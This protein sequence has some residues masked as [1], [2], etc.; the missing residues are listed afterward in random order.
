MTSILDLVKEVNTDWKQVLLESIHPHASIIDAML[1]KE[2]LDIF[3]ASD[4]IFAAFDKFD[5]QDLKVVIVGQDCYHTPGMAHGLCFSVPNECGKIP[6]S[7]R[8]IFKELQ[9]EYGGPMRTETD[10]SDWAND[11]VLLLNCALT[12]RAHTAGSHLKYWKPVIDNIIEHI[13]LKHQRIV[14]M[15][16]GNF[17]QTYKDIIDTQK[18]LILTARHP[19]P[20]AASKGPFVGNMHFMLA[21]EYLE[22]HG[23]SAV[24]WVNNN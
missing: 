20:L 3:P 1:E 18:N 12:V 9:H 6:P 21:N 7:L 11:G 23:K 19:S 8:V 2:P 17:A 15:L 16:W 14:F 5:Q 10:L 22:T 13:A 4:K 24:S